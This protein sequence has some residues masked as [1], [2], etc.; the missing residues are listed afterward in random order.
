MLSSFY[1]SEA[2]VTCA[3]ILTMFCFINDWKNF[4]YSES[5]LF[6]DSVQNYIILFSILNIYNRWV[7]ITVI[8]INHSFFPQLCVFSW[9]CFFLSSYFLI[10]WQMLSLLYNMWCDLRKPVTWCNIDILSY[11]YHDW[12][13]FNYSF[14]R[15][16]YL[17]L[18]R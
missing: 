11:W 16:F 5:Q 3:F 12:E 8:N 14:S 13:S 17:D 9:L 4:Y 10:K 2:C 15:P 6:Q 1:L 18:L 7:F